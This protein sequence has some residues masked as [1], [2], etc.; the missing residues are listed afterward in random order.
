MAAAPVASSQLSA[1][2]PATNVAVWAYPQRPWKGGDNFVTQTIV[3]DLGATAFSY[4]AV[5]ISGTNFLSATLQAN[6]TNVWTS[7]AVNINISLIPDPLMSVG[8]PTV[9]RGIFFFSASRAAIAHRYLR[10]IIFAPQG[11]DDFGAYTVGCFF[12]LFA[13]TE[14][15][16]RTP[17][18]IGRRRAVW[19]NELTQGDS[20]VLDAGRQKAFLRVPW[21]FFMNTR[22]GAPESEEAVMLLLAVN[23]HEPVVVCRDLN[24]THESFLCRRRGDIEWQTSDGLG[25]NFPMEFEEI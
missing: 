23:E 7:P 4:P 3:L 15:E 21:E 12:P 20:E 1:A 24:R 14:F 13:W 22:L 19:R 6:G 17:W 10:L 2:Y 18:T 16:N 25:V 8:G 5:Y 9:R 11:T